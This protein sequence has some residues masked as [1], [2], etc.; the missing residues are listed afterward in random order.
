MNA[1]RRSQ[2]WGKQRYGTRKLAIEARQ[3]WA[4]RKD[5]EAL[6]WLV[7]PY[8]C[9]FCHSWHLGRS[10]QS[11]KRYVAYVEEQMRLGREQ[12]QSSDGAA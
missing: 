5:R 4:E 12:A 9:P 2:C 6:L 10:K 3:Q 7:E 8:E 1:R 11:R